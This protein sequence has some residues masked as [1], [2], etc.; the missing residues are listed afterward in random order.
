MSYTNPLHENRLI[1]ISR[2]RDAFA[3]LYTHEAPGASSLLLEGAKSEVVYQVNEVGTEND[4]G[5]YHFPFLFHAN[6][7]PWQEANAYLLWLMRDR[8]PLNR[9][10]DDVRRCASKL[11]DYLLFCEDSNL[12]WLDFSGARPPLRPTYKYYYK[13][14]IDGDRSSAVIN[15]YTAA[16][17]HF[18]K[19]VSE[20][21]HVLDM[22]RV[23]TSKQVR[24]IIQNSKGTRVIKVER[25]SQTRRA[26]ANSAVPIGFVREDG[27]DLRPLSNL[28]LGT[29]LD[30]INNEKKWSTVERLI[31]L[32]SLMTGAR[33]QTVLTIR[34]K[35]LKAFQEDRLLPEGAY[36]LHAGPGTDIDT[37][38]DKAQTLYFPKQLADELIMLSSSPMM[39]V[40]R[41]KLRAQLEEDYP[42]LSMDESDMYLFVSDQGN[43]YYMARS[44]PR[45]SAVRSPQKGQV[46][47]TIKKKLLQKISSEFPNDFSYHWLRATY[48]YQLYQRLQVLVKDG[49]MRLG[50]DIDFI[51]KRMHHES[52]ETTESYLKLFRVSHEKVIA[53]EVWENILFNGAYS[54]LEVRAEDEC[55]RKI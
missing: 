36:K 29:F 38:N 35:H 4:G 3:S 6:G 22:K 25:R 23:D 26:P 40:R 54:V 47:G 42:S 14:I 2:V 10:T 18:Y 51:Q 1:T 28:E 15:Q 55:S 20:Y 17:Y 48:A 45:Y 44:D 31:L 43:C 39:K 19:Y 49:L 30:T 13:L 41:E 12:H 5:L 8:S 33:K 21:W 7:D 34:L 37:K 50:E 46:T 27:E 11:L 24:L 9:R 16:V 52:R 32:T 53:Q